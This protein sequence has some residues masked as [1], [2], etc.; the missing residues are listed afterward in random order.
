MIPIGQAKNQMDVPVNRSQIA[1][2][3]YADAP[4]TRV[5]FQS[6]L[7]QA[8]MENSTGNDD[9]PLVSIGKISDK[10]PTVSELLYASGYKKECW[11]I[12][13]EKINSSKPF[14]QIQPGTEIY[15]DR[16][17]SEIVWG[18]AAEER[19]YLPGFSGR[20][21]SDGHLKVSKVISHEDFKIN[22]GENAPPLSAVPLNHAVKKFI[23]VDYHQMDCYEMVVEGLKEMGVSYRGQNGL[24]RYLVEKAVGEGRPS[25]HYLNGEGLVD[26]AGEQAYQKRLYHV[27]DPEAQARKIMSD[28]E[29]LLKPGQI[30]SFS[31][32]SRGH[33]GVISKQDETWTF[34]NSGTMDNDLSGKSGSKGVGEERLSAEI[35]NWLELAEKRGEGLLIT[36][37]D[38]DPVKLTSYGNVLN[39]KASLSVSG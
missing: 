5:G 25:N 2:K 39:R 35:E 9:D 37:G 20:G 11:D 18:E 7:Q 34:I 26:A 1:V 23:G 4:L 10:I 12:L 24:G 28:M 38:I 36:L 15:L 3:A 32:R 13:G 33:T 22:K 16:R 17:T 30:L 8:S 31:T 29:S 6:L 27:E 14:R 21:D 19:L